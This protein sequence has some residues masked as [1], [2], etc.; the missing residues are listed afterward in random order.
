ML[1]NVCPSYKSVNYVWLCRF[2][3]PASAMRFP[4]NWDMEPTYQKINRE[5]SLIDTLSLEMHPW[6]TRCWALG[7]SGRSVPVFELSEYLRVKPP[8][9]L[10]KWKE[11]NHYQLF[12]SKIQF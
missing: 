9:N 11:I 2:L 6:Y 4:A 7:N 5:V 1:V 3:F 12:G 10:E 8:Y